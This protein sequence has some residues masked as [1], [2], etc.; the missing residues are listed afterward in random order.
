MGTHSLNRGWIWGEQWGSSL[1]ATLLAP[2]LPLSSSCRWEPRG[3]GRVQSLERVSGAG[4]ETAPG[5][6]YEKGPS[7]RFL[8]PAS[9]HGCGETAIENKEETAPFFFKLV[10]VSF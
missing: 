6:E 10:C 7:F 9:A 1:L 8:D 4:L 2:A 5:E 3:L